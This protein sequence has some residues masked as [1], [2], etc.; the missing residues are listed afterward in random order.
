MR[1][2]VNV[3]TLLLAERVGNH[4]RRIRYVCGS[5]VA[6]HDRPCRG[7]EDWSSL[8][9]WCGERSPLHPG[10]VLPELHVIDRARRRERPDVRILVSSAVRVLATAYGRRA[11]DDAIQR[12][13]APKR[14]GPDQRSRE[15][16]NV[17]PTPRR[18]RATEETSSS[19]VEVESVNVDTDTHGETIEAESAFRGSRRRPRLRRFSAWCST[20]PK[21]AG[22][23]PVD[24]ADPPARCRWVLVPGDS[25]RPVHYGVD[26]EGDGRGD[27]AFAPLHVEMVRV[28]NYRGIE[29]CEIELE[30]RLTLL[31]GRN[32]A[33]KSRILRALGIAL[34]GFPAELDDLTIG[35]TAPAT[36]DL[37]VSPPAPT[38]STDEEVFDKAVAQRLAS[39]QTLRE[40]PLRERFAWRTTIRRS[41]EGLGARADMQLLTFDD[42]KQGWVLR[43]RH[44][45]GSTGQLPV[46]GSTRDS[47]PTSVRRQ[48]T[49]R[50]PNC[51]P[52]MSP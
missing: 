18:L 34:G 14:M 19:V 22:S 35:S 9:I 13:A 30:P 12:C 46:W 44:K 42:T 24:L 20:S 33:G 37:V 36:I 11:V 45:V 7:R 48:T 32:N 1:R 27:Q 51:G 52:S 5:C 16:P 41:S 28:A 38:S 29:S 2:N 4:E 49:T 47:S 43:A 39:I 15:G 50:L 8:A 10:D 21:A 25:V 40:E 6:D 23:A 17:E 26:H 31:V 3:R